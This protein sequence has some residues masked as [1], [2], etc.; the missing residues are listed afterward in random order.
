MIQGPVELKS[1]V[2]KFVLKNAAIPLFAYLQSRIFAKRIHNNNV[3]GKTL[4]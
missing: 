4:K 3:I 2:G 1:L